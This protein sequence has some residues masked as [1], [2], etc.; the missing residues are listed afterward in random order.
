MPYSCV[1]LLVW[2]VAL[3]CSAF[4]LWCYDRFVMIC[5]SVNPFIKAI[6]TILCLF[7]SSV[8][9]YKFNHAEWCE[10]WIVYVY[11]YKY[12]F[13]LV[14]LLLHKPGC[15]ACSLWW[16]CWR[17]YVWIHSFL[18]WFEWSWQLLA[19]D[20]FIVLVQNPGA[21][22][23]LTA[24]HSIAEI[25]VTDPYSLILLIKLCQAHFLWVFLF[26][27]LLKTIFGICLFV[28]LPSVNQF[29][30][31]AFSCYKFLLCFFNP[32]IRISGWQKIA[33]C[34]KWLHFVSWD[35]TWRQSW[36]QT[37]LH[38]A[39]KCFVMEAKVVFLMLLSSICIYDIH[40]FM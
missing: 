8:I 14:V 34:S 33:Y 21:L 20:Q 5:M 6:V 17:H 35:C 3:L 38:A 36:M 1:C 18:Y 19:E 15:G 22:V 11:N 24:C 32:F 37:N 16:F 10:Y 27:F 23:S 30:L 28:I 26:Q 2:I 40:Q 25:L 31:S 7:P 13:V 12:C 29:R 39:I 9:L 4:Q